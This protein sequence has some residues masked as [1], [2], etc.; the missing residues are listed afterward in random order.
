MMGF[1][2]PRGNAGGVARFSPAILHY[3]KRGKTATGEIVAVRVAGLL[4]A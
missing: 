2:F 1:K 4:P 3:P